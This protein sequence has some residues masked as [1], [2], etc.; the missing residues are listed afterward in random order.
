M[1]PLDPIENINLP[2]GA[3]IIETWG[4]TQHFAEKDNGLQLTAEGRRALSPS[5]IDQDSLMIDDSIAGSIKSRERIISPNNSR[6]VTVL[7]SSMSDASTTPSKYASAIIKKWKAPVFYSKSG[8][9]IK[10]RIDDALSLSTSSNSSINHLIDSSYPIH[11]NSR[12]GS[13]AGNYT[14]EKLR[15]GLNRVS[16]HGSNKNNK[17][18]M[19]GLKKHQMKRLSGSYE[20]PPVEYEKYLNHHRN[21][22]SPNGRPN[23]TGQINSA[24]SPIQQ[25][26]RNGSQSCHFPPRRSSG[27][28]GE[29]SPDKPNYID[30]SLVGPTGRKLDEKVMN[31][32]AYKL[33]E[34]LVRDVFS[35]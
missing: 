1:N 27:Q 12:R 21:D 9:G 34:L 33:K 32:T 14:E 3:V 19:T 13:T 16:E 20:I 28:F 4:Q 8:T 26:L 25:D 29:N 2:K 11:I 22:R 35:R 10:E 24:F 7:R 30:D 5:R 6:S 17:A 31:K 18:L 23:T 15:K